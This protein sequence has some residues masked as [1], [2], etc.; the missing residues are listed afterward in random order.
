[1]VRFSDAT[2][3]LARRSSRSARAVSSR[4]V[5]KLALKVELVLC[6]LPRDEQANGSLLLSLYLPKL[7]FCFGGPFLQGTVFLS[8]HSLNAGDN[9]FG[10]LDHT[11]DLAPDQLLQAFRPDHRLFTAQPPVAQHSVAVI[12][13]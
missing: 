5:M 11:L 8:V 9:E 2:D 1:M 7:T 4:S 10:M 3:S 13:A 6:D 12:V